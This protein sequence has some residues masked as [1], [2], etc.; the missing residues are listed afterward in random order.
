MLGK[1]IRYPAVAGSFY[2]FE[3][4]K[5]EKE[6]S[7]YLNKAKR[8]NLSGK[9]RIL[10]VPHAGIIYSGQT[11]AW[12]FKQLQKENFKRI[13]LLGAS[14]TSWF[15]YVAVDDNDFWLTPLG[16]V[17]IDKKF[18]FQ[19]VDEEKIVIDERPFVKE[20]CL[21]VELIFLQKVLT[22]FKIVPILVSEVNENL[23]NFLAQKIADNFDDDTLLVVSSD[24][25]HYPSNN[26]A[27]IA[28]KKT[29]EAI[30]T[31]KKD[32]FEKAILEVEKKGFFN[33]QTA[34]CGQKAIAVALLIADNL[35]IKDFRLLHYSNSGDIFGEKTRVVGYA[36]IGASCKNLPQKTELLDEKAQKEALKVARETLKSYL[37]KGMI[38]DFEI[39]NSNLLKPLGC[40]VTLRNKG[41]LRGCI[42]EFEPEEPLWK[43]IRRVAI[44]AATADF[45]FLPVTKEELP[46]IEI[47]ISVMTPR[48]LIDDWRKIKLGKQGVVVEGYGRGGTFLPQVAKETGWSLEEFLSYLC[49]EKAGLP[50]NCYKDP[51]VK[52]YTFEVQEI[53]ERLTSN[54]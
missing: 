45:R 22:D 27:K 23:E 40:F 32:E 20:H 53:K 24:L 14:H 4:E 13:I 31:G 35:Q 3:K 8:I 28:D 48:K 49:S 38:P 1:K 10:I 54:T 46:S 44:K 50:P 33:L 7:S 34:A 47:E 11:A 37:E 2:P 52:I 5:L 18:I 25:S 30:L 12:G 21:E 17:A 9:L 43:V 42:G 51:E 36:A 19:I 15:S 29:I 39:K 26:D 16:K 41:Q 6:I